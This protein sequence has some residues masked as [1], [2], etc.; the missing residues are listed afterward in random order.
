MVKILS[1]YFK[2]YIK[3]DIKILKIA[4]IL[5]MKSIEILLILF[6][7]SILTKFNSTIH[8]NTKIIISRYNI[9]FLM[10]KNKYA[11]MKLSKYINS[12]NINL[13]N[14]KLLNFALLNFAMKI[15]LKFKEKF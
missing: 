10:F 7:I 8:W 2:S 6:S 11:N 14:I 1:K 4:N 15:F 9:S 5:I 12:E 3:E 13:K